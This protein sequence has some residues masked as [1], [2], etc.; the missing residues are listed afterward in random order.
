MVLNKVPDPRQAH[1]IQMVA[2]RSAVTSPSVFAA[3]RHIYQS[4]TADRWIGL[5]VTI[6]LYALILSICLITTTF[7]PRPA[8][9]LT[10][11]N[12]R[13]EASL[14]ENRP[15]EEEA[16]KPVEEKAKPVEP[17]KVQQTERSIIPVAPIATPLPPPDPKPS[18]PSASERQSAAPRTVP[19]RP[20]PQ[21]SSKRPDSWEGR[22]LA[23]LNTQRRYPSGAMRL[24]QQGVP[25]I[26]IV[27]DRE[28]KVLSSRLERS[29]GFFELD[30]EAVALP[31]RA[32][33]FPKPPAAGAGDAV[34]LIV[35][36]EFFFT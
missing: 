14:P 16:P 25:Y 12:L 20:A 23:A 26:R 8:S 31:K 19:A 34:E 7:P 32:S 2:S 18:E 30:R 17:V 3:D 5:L 36:V 9:T 13:P 6:A 11:V 27:I 22:V 24:R 29:S 4:A 15:Q 10:V 21:L 28:G 35:P 33:P 1:E